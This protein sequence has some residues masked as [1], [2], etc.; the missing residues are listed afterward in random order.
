MRSGS[1]YTDY[2][3]GDLVEYQ[4]EPAIAHSGKF[5]YGIVVESSSIMPI[6]FMLNGSLAGGVF[7]V[8]KLDW[9]RKLNA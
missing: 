2:K 1:K 6:V 4:P 5:W 9:W 7:A 8:I 3:V